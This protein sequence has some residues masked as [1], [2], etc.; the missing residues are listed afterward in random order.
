MRT[1]AWKRVEELFEAALREPPEHRGRFL[2]QAC[3]DDPELRGEVLSLLNSADSASS[4]LEDSPV[5]AARPSVERGTKLGHFEIL[6]L[7]GRGGMGD[8]YRAR[9]SHLKR[10]VAIK[11]LPPDAARDPTSIVR[12]EREARAASALNHPNILQISGIGHAAGT[13]WIASELLRGESLRQVIER[14]ALTARRATE[15]A[16]QIADGLAAAHAAGIVHRDLN[17][18]NV[19]IAPD[20]RVKILD[21][22]LAT[23]APGISSASGSL[24]AGITTPGLVMGTP[25]YMAP[26][27]IN[28]KPADSR[29]DIFALGV[30]LHEMLSGARAFNG[31]S[32]IEVLNAN[33]KAEPAELSPSVPLALQRITARCIEKEPTRRFQSAADLSFAL[34]AVSDA[35]ASRAPATAAG[36]PSWPKWIAA[37]LAV[38][39]LGAGGAYWVRVHISEQQSSANPILSRL[40]YDSG[41]NHR[42]RNFS[43]RQAR[44]VCK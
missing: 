14:G 16:I 35:S 42:W 41:L 9:D 38:A 28:G 23:R 40:T 6:E 33:L 7:I 15:I 3:P 12:F 32:T 1:E 11:V 37:T 21:F 8:V 5:P 17:P 31:G 39:I 4:F 24:P 27:Q 22:G 25:G 13:Y 26:E 18:G 44:R 10:D 43:R 34:A 29:S 36:R 19:M 30:L 20:G 2:A